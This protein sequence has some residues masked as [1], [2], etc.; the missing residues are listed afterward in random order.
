[1]FVLLKK[2]IKTSNVGINP[3]TSFG[4]AASVLGVYLS[5]TPV[6]VEFSLYLSPLSQ[7]GSISADLSSPSLS[8]KRTFLYKIT[9]VSGTEF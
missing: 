1:M 2:S 5:L 9:I 7:V 6:I 4:P 3:Y 8:L